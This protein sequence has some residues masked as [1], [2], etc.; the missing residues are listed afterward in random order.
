MIDF[1][2]LL[3]YVAMAFIL[4][5]YFRMGALKVDG[6]I[7][8]CLG[9]ALLVVFGIFD[10]VAIGIAIGNAVIFLLTIRGFIRWRKKLR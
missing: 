6:W 1:L 4:L 5:G 9:S 10:T 7:W 3:G 2:Q 8:T